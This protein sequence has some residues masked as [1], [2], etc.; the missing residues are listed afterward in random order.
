MNVWP[1]IDFGKPLEALVNLGPLLSMPVILNIRWDAMLSASEQPKWAVF[2]VLG[3]ALSI[4]MT[5]LLARRCRTRGEDVPTMGICGIL[6]ALFFVGLALGTTYAVNTM[7]SLNRLA[8][9]CAGGITF[10]SVAWSAHHRKEYTSWLQWTVMLSALILS[11]FFWHGY[12]IDFPRPDFNKSVRFSRIGH[13][14][15]TADALMSLIPLLF[16]TVANQSSTGVR[17]AAVFSLLTTGFMLLTSGSLG[18]MGGL[19]IGGLIAGGYVILRRLVA[20]STTSLLPTKKQIILTL[21]FSLGVLAVAK[22]VFDHMPEQFRSQMFTR[23]E[24]W[25]AP[26]ADK[27]GKASNVPPLASLW[28]VA[29]PYLGSRTPMWAST[30]GMIAEHPWRGFGTGSFLFEYPAF[31]KRYDLFHDPETMGVK[32]KTNPHNLFLRIAAENGLPMAALFSGLYL[33]L[34]LRVMRQAWRE[35]SAFWVCGVSAL[36]AIALDTQVN[37]VFFNPASLFMASVAL[38]IWYGRLPKPEIPKG[39]SVCPLWRNTLTPWLLA[40]PVIWLASHPIRWLI[41][42]YFVAKATEL[43]YTSTPKI[44]RPAWKEALAWSPSNYMAIYG[45]AT[46]AYAT[47]KLAEAEQSLVDFLRIYPNHSAALNLL[48]TIHAKQERFD[49]AEQ[50]LQQAIAL[51]P[52]SQPL[53][54][55]LAALR[56]FRAE[57]NKKADTAPTK[58][59]AVP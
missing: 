17:L 3:V 10:V 20:F 7:E 8:F 25:G 15:F 23:A 14:N 29:L 31:Q 49:M 51:E 27:L 24:W 4:A 54:D 59:D 55:N 19:L 36:W 16:W 30:A 42:E 47:G 56:K 37:H 9:W 50:T 46:N 41:S 39:L 53:K 21:G 57:R 5:I 33:W 32:I 52:N 11:L 26:T 40:L 13:F 45:L 1:R 18:G 2:L 38:G 58:P 6:F 43:Q 35:P 48:A 44:A 22:P 34:L 12:L 28:M